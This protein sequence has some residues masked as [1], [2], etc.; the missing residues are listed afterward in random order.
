MSA[1]AEC[2]PVVPL[3]ALLPSAA[4]LFRAAVDLAMKS[5]S[6]ETPRPFENMRE[7]I[8]DPEAY[9]FRCR[10]DADDAL[11]PRSDRLTWQAWSAETLTIRGFQIRATVRAFHIIH[12]GAHITIESLD[13]SPLPFTETGYKSLF[14][15]FAQLAEYETPEQFVRDLFPAEP[16][17]TGL[18]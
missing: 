9:G 5:P 8:P 3:E 17:Q 1:P 11:V 10:M 13:R 14:V 4:A 6:L 12:Y 18:F 2:M 16:I 7:L 15:A